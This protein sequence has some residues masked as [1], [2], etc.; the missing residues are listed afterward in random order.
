MICLKI[1]DKLSE[2]FK[3]EKISVFITSKCWFPLHGGRDHETSCSGLG[4][5]CPDME[6]HNWMLREGTGTP[7]FDNDLCQNHIP[8]PGVMSCLSRY[9]PRSLPTFAILQFIFLI[10]SLHLNET[11]TSALPQIQHN[12]LSVQAGAAPPSRLELWHLGNTLEKWWFS[13]GLAL[14]GEAG[15]FWRDLQNTSCVHPGVHMH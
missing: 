3:V 4:A 6:K 7:P 10:L 11:L 2:S 13:L 12:P 1:K 15:V 14:I 9:L 8:A 5:V